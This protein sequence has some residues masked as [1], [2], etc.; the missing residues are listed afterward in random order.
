MKIISEIFRPENVY[1]C[2]YLTRF[3][4]LHMDSGNSADI[5]I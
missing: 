5:D 4:K 1:S 3:Q 2:A